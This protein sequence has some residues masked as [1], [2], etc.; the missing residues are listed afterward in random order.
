MSRRRLA[1]AL[2]AVGCGGEAGGGA[3]TLAEI[4]QRVFSR[5]CTFDPC[6]GGSNPQQG[7]SLVSPT[8]DALVGR[9]AMQVPGRMR[10]VP[11]DP[12][13][14]YL[15]EKIS[16]DRPAMGQRMPPLQPLDPE[17]I[18]LVRAWI[19]AGARPGP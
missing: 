16:Q 11:G 7:L 5:S 2:L 4:E 14:S 6:H 17:R 19:A 12:A 1:L 9:P 8:H 18:E 13:A 10:V 15:F 3:P